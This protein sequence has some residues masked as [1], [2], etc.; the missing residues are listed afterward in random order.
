MSRD[1]FMWDWNGTLVYV[2]FIIVGCSSLLPWNSVITA[3]Q[4]FKYKYCGTDLEHLFETY[5]T[6]QFTTAQLLG[7]FSQLYLELRC[8]YLHTV[9]KPLF[10]SSLLFSMLFISTY[11]GE[12]LEGDAYFYATSPLISL[13]GYATIFLTSGVFA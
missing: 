9:T 1:P 8:G 2:V 5:Y 4:F 3:T 6:I 11:L 7:L 12:W 13:L 10:F